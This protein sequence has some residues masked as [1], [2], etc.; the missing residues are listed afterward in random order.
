ML[1]IIEVVLAN[2]IVLA[3]KYIFSND[4]SFHTPASTDHYLLHYNTKHFIIR[5]KHFRP[6]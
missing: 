6:I 4:M 3:F 2:L 5:R 1:F